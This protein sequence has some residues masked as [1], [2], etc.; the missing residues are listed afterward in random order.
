LHT[1]VIERCQPDNGLER[2]LHAFRI[3]DR[4][5]VSAVLFREKQDKLFHGYL[6]AV[7]GARQSGRKGKTERADRSPIAALYHGLLR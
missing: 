7:F 3:Q 6:P 1:T 2:L 4:Q 5:G